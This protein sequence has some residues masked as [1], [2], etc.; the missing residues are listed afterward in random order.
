MHRLATSFFLCLLYCSFTLSAQLSDATFLVQKEFIVH[1]F[2]QF[3]TELEEAKAS[4]DPGKEAYTH[5]HFG[6]FYLNIGVS[7]EAMV[8]FN[9]AAT[10][11]SNTQDTLLVYIKNGLGQVE[12]SLK[13]YQQAEIFFN[14]AVAIAS[15][16]SFYG[17]L[18]ISNG[19]LGTSYEKRELFLEALQYQKKSLELFSSLHDKQGVSLVYENIG[20]IYEDLEQYKEALQYFNKAYGLVKNDNTPREANVLNNLGDIYR[21]TGRF[22]DGLFYTEQALELGRNIKDYH[23]V[24]SAYKDLSKVYAAMDNYIEAYTYLQLSEQMNADLFYAQNT[25]QIN[26]LQTVYESKKKE[27]Q[28]NLLQEE[29]KVA[30]AKHQLLIVIIFAFFVFAS[31]MTIYFFKKRQQQLQLKE[32]E[33]KM[34]KAELEKKAVEEAQLHKEVQLKTAALSTYSLQLSQKNKMLSEVAHTLKNLSG[35]N[36]MNI[37]E[38]IKNLSAEIDAAT[39]Y[40]EEWEEFTG[41][42]KD[43]HPNFIHQLSAISTESLSSAELRLAMLLRLHLSSKEIASILRVTPDSVRVARYRL[44]KKLPIDAKE[45]L[46]TFLITL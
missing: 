33:Q 6:V 11:I 39:Q 41:Y 16:T 29:G 24:E 15:K 14:E 45:D 31:F 20:S 40:D 12:L 26:V 21:K 27:A 35:R 42:F 43:I 18:A 28:I 3:K 37:S 4:K 38:K 34:L 9:A 36:N 5:Y 30:A 10:L 17:G 19:W 1:N 25:N 13:N 8:E 2:Q 22:K 7:S 32:Y 46:V 44:R 23:Q